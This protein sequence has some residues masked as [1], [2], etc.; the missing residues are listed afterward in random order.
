MAE[1]AGVPVGLGSAEGWTEEIAGLVT[2]FGV[3]G[4]VRRGLQANVQATG[5]TNS[6]SQWRIRAYFISGPSDF[7]LFPVRGTAYLS[8]AQDTDA[9]LQPKILVRV[10]S[11]SAMAGSSR[12]QPKSWR[13]PYGSFHAYNHTPLSLP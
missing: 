1:G 5:M 4:A 11:T 7:T 2:G 8:R 6:N 13:T 12:R 9:I 3:S 10:N